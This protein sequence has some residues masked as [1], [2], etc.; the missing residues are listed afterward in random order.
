MS[1]VKLA[2]KWI[3]RVS[4]GLLF[5]IFVTLGVVKFWVGWFWTIPQNGMYPNIPSGLSFFAIDNPYRDVTQVNRGDVVVFRRV[6]GA[7][8]YIYIWRVVGLP[9]DTVEIDDARVILNGKKL[10]QEK[11]RSEGDFEIF[12][13]TNGTASYEVAYDRTP[14]AE[15]PRSLTLTVPDDHLFLL[16]DNRRAASDSRVMGPIP[17]PSVVARRW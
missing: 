9:G 4:L 14:S 10:P 13:E 5:A 3:S 12:R 6:E 17:F 8:R 15:S 11:S 1:R 2:V 16:G 7:E